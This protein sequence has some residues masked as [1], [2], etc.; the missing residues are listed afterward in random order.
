ME[1]ALGLWV[2]DVIKREG[3]G[4]E[5]VPESLPPVPPSHPRRLGV[6]LI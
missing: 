6:L 2:D 1:V 4:A 3:K 5:P